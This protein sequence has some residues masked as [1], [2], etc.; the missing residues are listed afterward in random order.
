MLPAKAEWRYKARM[1]A[2]LRG[3]EGI[4]VLQ[5]ATIKH[6]TRQSDEFEWLHMDAGT[7]SNLS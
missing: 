5:L 4:F 6:F 2:T 7:Q 1:N 3:I